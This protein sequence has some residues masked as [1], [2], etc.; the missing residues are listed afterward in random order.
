M[1]QFITRNPHTCGVKLYV[2]CGAQ[3]RYIWH[4][5]LYHGAG[6]PCP[7]DG[8]QGTTMLLQLWNGGTKKPL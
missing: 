5:Y 8:W 2:L 1:R 6:P 4:F 7:A 3:Q